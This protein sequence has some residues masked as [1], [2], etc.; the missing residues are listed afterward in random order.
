MHVTPQQIRKL[1]TH[2]L[3]RDGI[4]VPG[5]HAMQPAA[6]WNFAL[7]GS[8]LG[9]Q[10][11]QSPVSIYEGAQGLLNINNFVLPPVCLGLLPTAT[12]VHFPGCAAELA[13]LNLNIAN[14][15]AGNGGAQALCQEALLKILARMNGLIPVAGNDRYRLHMKATTWFGWDHFALSFR[16]EQPGRPRIFVQTVTGS[17][18]NHACDCIWDEDLE[19]AEINI[20]ELH[21]LQVGFINNVNTFGD[22]C[23]ECGAEHGPDAST[24]FH[25]HRCTVCGAVYCP[26]HGFQLNGKRWNEQSRDCGQLGCAGRTSIVYEI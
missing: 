16:P 11:A 20:Q 9:M 6:C 4:P 8:V 26:L 19:G 25:W 22:L 2:V 18:L 15:V 10:H 13:V 21:P 3:S 17:T 12:V 23:V 5:S 24:I 7:T 14:A 1:G